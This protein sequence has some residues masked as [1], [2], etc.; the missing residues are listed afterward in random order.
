MSRPKPVEKRGERWNRRPWATPPCRAL[1]G[2]LP[3]ELERA[4][5]SRSASTAVARA[6]LGGR[7]IGP[8]REFRSISFDVL[9]RASERLL[10]WS[11]SEPGDERGPVL[12]SPP[13]LGSHYAAMEATYRTR[14]CGS[15][16]TDRS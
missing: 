12:T 5:V 4:S 2:L 10:G 11:W 13:P 3:G 6:A 7:S 8:A 9:R 14:S 15:S 16:A 1:P